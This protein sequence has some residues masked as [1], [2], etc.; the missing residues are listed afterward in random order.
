MHKCHWIIINRAQKPS[1]NLFHDFQ[2]N[3]SLCLKDWEQSN[4]LSFLEILLMVL[5]SFSS[6]FYF[7]MTWVKGEW[8]FEQGRDEGISQP[9]AT[10][11]NVDP[12]WLRI[13]IVKIHKKGKKFTTKNIKFRAAG[14][15]QRAQT[16]ITLQVSTEN[17]TRLHASTVQ[18]HTHTASI[19]SICPFKSTERSIEG[20]RGW[21]GKPEHLTGWSL[22]GEN[23]ASRS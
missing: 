4:L 6:G 1:C 7:G 13:A 17:S 15:L 5:F 19:M 23:V 9:Y 20:D 12:D 22:R 8:G 11:R 3:W 16:L 18:T 21:C 10:A 2:I 14:H